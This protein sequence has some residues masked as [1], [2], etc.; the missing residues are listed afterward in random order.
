MI[1]QDMNN[2]VKSCVETYSQVNISVGDIYASKIT[3][4]W[5]TGSG[6]C[7]KIEDIPLNKRKPNEDE[8]GILFN[9]SDGNYQIR[10][11]AHNAPTK[12]RPEGMSNEKLTSTM[13]TLTRS[14]K[15][16][17]YV[18][19]EGCYQML[20]REKVFVVRNVIPYDNLSD[21]QMTN[22]QFKSFHK[23][24]K[25]H[26][27]TPLELMKSDDTLWGEL[28]APD[29]LKEA[30]MLYCLSPKNKT[31]MLHIGLVTSM[32]EGKDH[33]IDHVISPL[34]PVGVAGSGKMSTIAGLFG[35]MDGDDLQSIDLG[36]IPKHNNERMAV[37]EFQTWDDT[38]FGELMNVMANG[39]FTMQKG[40]LDIERPGK[41]NMLFLGNPP[42]HYDPEVHTK[43]DGSPDKM[44]MLESF[45]Q[46]TYQ[47]L[48]RLTLIFTQMSLSGKDAETLI[49]DKILDAIGG[50]YQNGSIKEQMIMWRTFFR[51]YLRYVSAMEPDYT[52]VRQVLKD[53]YHHDIKSTGAFKDI[54][55]QRSSKDMRKFQEF[56]NLCRGYARLYGAEEV[57]EVHIANAQNI[58]NI[59]LQTLQKDFPLDEMN[60]LGEEA[61]KLSQVHRE[62]LAEFGDT[63]T[64][65][66]AEIKKN[67]KISDDDLQKMQEAGLLDIME[68]NNTDKSFVILKPYEPDYD[69]E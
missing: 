65:D 5:V 31:D 2:F 19:V 16:G 11:L 57:A 29:M 20:G 27:M 28:Y 9:I 32:G 26:G 38:V 22:E 6:I 66:V 15:N 41:V 54:F 35:A 60:V 30:V 62:L 61:F 10:C 33:L 12:V 21:S 40:Q 13:L 39:K 53:T 49:E 14:I 1:A 46:Y 52:T 18:S 25:L 42:R 8:V 59:S 4:E 67:K 56:I 3:N 34:V 63:G 23:K 51:E 64:L 36:L 37:S 45:G 50:K 7:L 55:L 69:D 44:V 47:I 17:M 43:K 68:T 48:S 58:F 24:C